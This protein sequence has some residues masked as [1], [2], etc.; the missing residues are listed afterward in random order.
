MTATAPL[1]RIPSPHDIATNPIY[2]CGMWRDPAT[3]ANLPEFLAA[4]VGRV[5]ARRILDDADDIATGA[6]AV[7]RPVKQPGPRPGVDRV[8]SH[9]GVDHDPIP[10]RQVTVCGLLI[11]PP[12]IYDYAGATPCPDCYEGATP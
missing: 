4:A 6:R 10:L 9:D 1:V 2:T 11:P 3:G 5:E 7:P 12:F 8:W